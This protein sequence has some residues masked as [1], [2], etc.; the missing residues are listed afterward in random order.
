MQLRKHLGFAGVLPV[1]GICTPQNAVPLTRKA[2]TPMTWWGAA[3][4]GAVAANTTTTAAAA[5]GVTKESAAAKG[6]FG[7]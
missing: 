7:E 3:V 4:D 1:W 5:A 2:P 6:V